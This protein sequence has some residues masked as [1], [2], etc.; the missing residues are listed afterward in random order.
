MIYSRYVQS[1]SQTLSWKLQQQA[2]EYA[3]ILYIIF[4]SFNFVTHKEAF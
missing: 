4:F 3:E 2:T 1:Y